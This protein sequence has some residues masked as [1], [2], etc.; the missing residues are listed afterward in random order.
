MNFITNINSIFTGSPDITP[1]IV[2]SGNVNTGS[3]DL[4]HLYD[5]N[6][7]GVPGL[8][9]G[10]GSRN[11]LWSPGTFS[12]DIN[13]SKT[14]PIKE[15][16]GLELRASFFNPFN[17]VRR[18]DLNTAFTFKMKGKSLDD[19]YILNNSPEQNVANLLAQKPGGTPA[20]Q[21]NQYRGGVGHTNLTS[22]MDMRRIEIG[23]RLKF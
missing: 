10:S 20:H 5:V 13:V 21:Y 15:R 9:D 11:Y 4:A 22:V 19:G 8:S 16:L 17:Q 2:P 6:L 1:R 23:V 14:F 12:N 7:F 3:S 18:Q